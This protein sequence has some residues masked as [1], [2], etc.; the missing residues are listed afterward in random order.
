MGY[1]KDVVDNMPA[2]TVPGRAGWLRRFLSVHLRPSRAARLLVLDAN[3]APVANAEVRIVGLGRSKTN[4]RGVATLYV[5][6]AVYYAVVVTANGSEEV[7][8]F[9]TLE[10]GGSYVYRPDPANPAGRYAIL[11]EH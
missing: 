1:E 11:S 4:R 5:P 2:G 9:E 6:E 3:D 10:P 8:Y 7:M